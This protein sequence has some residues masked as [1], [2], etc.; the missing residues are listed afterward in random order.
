M[1]SE[2]LLEEEYRTYSDVGVV[3]CVLLVGLC[4]S[5]DEPEGVDWLG[6]DGKQD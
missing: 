6:R 2:S 1:S 3:S 4:A 5:V